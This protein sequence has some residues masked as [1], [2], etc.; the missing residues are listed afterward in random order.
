MMARKAQEWKAAT[1]K[2]ANRKLSKVAWNESDANP[3]EEKSDLGKKSLDSDQADHD[4][5]Q[6]KSE[7]LNRPARGN[8]NDDVEFAFETSR[9]GK[10]RMNVIL[11]ISFLGLISYV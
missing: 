9:I 2:Q 5:N 11:W 6:A 1:E 10:I 4:P 7:F 3:W 8:K